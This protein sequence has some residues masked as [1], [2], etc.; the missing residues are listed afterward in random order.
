MKLKRIFL[1]TKHILKSLCFL[2]FMLS[3]NLQTPCSWAFFTQL[4]LHPGASYRTLAAVV[5]LDT[6]AFTFSAQGDCQDLLGFPLLAP[7]PW[8]SFQTVTLI[9]V[10]FVCFLCLVLEVTICSWN[11]KAKMFAL[12]SSIVLGFNLHF[13][14][15]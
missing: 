3:I 4:S 8:H 9:I 13:I 5:S 15:G 11:P 10:Q 14:G 12:V 6:S 7:W 2:Q 1:C